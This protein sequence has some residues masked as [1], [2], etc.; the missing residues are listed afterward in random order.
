MAADPVSLEHRSPWSHALDLRPFRGTDLFQRIGGQPAIDRL[1]DLLYEGIRND[2]QLRPLFPRDLADSR[3]MQKLFFAQWL[4]GPRR[5]SAQAY[6]GLGPGHAGLPI[7]PALADRWLGHFRRAMEATVAAEDDRTTIFA[8]VHSL[9]WLS[10]AGGVQALNATAL[11]YAAR[12][13]FLQ[14]IVAAVYPRTS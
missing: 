9:P 1:V 14:T 7:T 2:G 3:S 11:H 5:Y 13:G 10:L 6:K 8:Q 12:T 4:D